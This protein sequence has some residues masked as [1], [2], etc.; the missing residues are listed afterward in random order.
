MVLLAL[1]VQKDHPG[2]EI[3][4]ASRETCSETIARHEYSPGHLSFVTCCSC[5]GPVFRHMPLEYSRSNFQRTWLL[6]SPS[7]PLLID[8]QVHQDKDNYFFLFLEPRPVLGTWAQIRRNK[9]KKPDGISLFLTNI[10]TRQL[11]QCLYLKS[12]FE[13]WTLFSHTGK[14]Y[15]ILW[16]HP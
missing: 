9:H 14:V 12:C 5:S 11:Y 15:P 1:S 2:E 6:R 7:P 8:H 3:V 16:W 13:F 10:S 4:R